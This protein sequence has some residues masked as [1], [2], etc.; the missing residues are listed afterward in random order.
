MTPLVLAYFVWKAVYGCD[1][2]QQTTDAIFWHAATYCEQH[3]VDVDAS[4]FDAQ[5]YIDGAVSSWQ[6]D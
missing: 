1:V 2:S 5:Y 6:G 4:S 3:P